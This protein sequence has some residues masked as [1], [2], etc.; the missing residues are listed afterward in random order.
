VAEQVRAIAT[1]DKI[2]T[3]AAQVFVERGYAGAGLAEIIAG[4]GMT[5][6]AFYFHFTSKADMAIAII[7]RQHSTWVP[8]QQTATEQGLQGLDAIRYLIDRVSQQMRDDVV[9]RAAIKLARELELIDADVISPFTDWSSC[10]G[11]NLRQAQLLGQMRND[12]DPTTYAG[13]LVGMFLGVEEFS[14]S[15]VNALANKNANARILNT[16][17]YSLDAMWEMVLR[18]LSV[19]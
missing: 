8:L 7:D 12:L 2:M 5:R 15:P 11:Y 3:S 1:R 13:V 4:S 16:T 17:H 19:R 9:A 14:Q 6:G 18:G 10:F